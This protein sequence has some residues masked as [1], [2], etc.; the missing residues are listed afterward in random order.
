[1]QI[2]I[3]SNDRF[4]MNAIPLEDWTVLRRTKGVVQSYNY[5]RNTAL[6]DEFKKTGLSNFDFLAMD[7]TNPDSDLLHD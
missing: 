6:F 3:S 7:F 5:T 1:M 2:V 4:V